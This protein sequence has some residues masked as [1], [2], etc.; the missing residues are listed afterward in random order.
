M[1]STAS[2]AFW[3]GFAIERASKALFLLREGGQVWAKEEYIWL[4]GEE[5]T[6]AW[7]IIHA[8]GE[9]AHAWQERWGA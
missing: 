5:A 6:E 7:G 4:Y 9:K 8:M 1:N 3:A 2:P